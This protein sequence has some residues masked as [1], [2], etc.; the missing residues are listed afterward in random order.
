MFAPVLYFCL[1]ER[2]RWKVQEAKPGRQCTISQYQHD[3]RLSLCRDHHTPL[4]QVF[5][6]HC[7][8]QALAQ[9][10]AQVV[11]E[12]GNALGRMAPLLVHRK[13]VGLRRLMIGQ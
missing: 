2:D 3:F 13:H 1:T 12:L 6:I 9:R 10:F 11:H 5:S 4:L 7:K 8:R